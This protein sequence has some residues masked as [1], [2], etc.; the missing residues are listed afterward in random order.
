MPDLACMLADCQPGGVEEGP[1]GG[2]IDREAPEAQGG[3]EDPEGLEEVL[4][5][6]AA[7]SQ[8]SSHAQDTPMITH[9]RPF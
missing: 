7:G 8:V 6:E 3:G 5:M 2:D 1:G 9:E 4:R